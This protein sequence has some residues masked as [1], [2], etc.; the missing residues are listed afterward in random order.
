MYAWFISLFLSCGGPNGFENRK[1]VCIIKR[2][3]YS[4][5][6]NIGFYLHSSSFCRNCIGRATAS[7]IQFLQN[8]DLCK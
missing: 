3:F 5:W 1:Y 2:S 6:L 7:P 4:V 8:E